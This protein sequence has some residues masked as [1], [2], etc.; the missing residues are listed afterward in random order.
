MKHKPLFDEAEEQEYRRYQ[1]P[2]EACSPASGHL[3]KMSGHHG[4]LPAVHEKRII[5]PTAKA[6][7]PMISP[8]QMGSGLQIQMSTASNENTADDF[9]LNLDEKPRGENFQAQYKFH[10][11]KRSEVINPVA[12]T[13]FSGKAAS[14]S[15]QNSRNPLGIVDLKHIAKEREKEDK[16][17]TTVEFTAS[18]KNIEKKDLENFSSVLNFEM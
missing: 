9:E 13:Y 2:S 15:H 4:L 3:G 11:R 1:Y 10:D 16:T 14:V 5:S 7:F 8:R 12:A 17:T 18:P 6:S